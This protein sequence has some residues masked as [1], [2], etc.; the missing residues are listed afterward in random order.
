MIQINANDNALERAKRRA[1]TIHNTVKPLDLTK[2]IYQVTSRRS[3]QVYI[4]RLSK[5]AQGNFAACTCEAG[6]NDRA[7][8][9]VPSVIF[10]NNALMKMRHATQRNAAA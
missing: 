9:H 8:H 3:G 1:L 10:V 5:T 4:V 6:L 2:R 7:C